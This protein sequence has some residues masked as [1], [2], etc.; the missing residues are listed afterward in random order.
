[1][2]FG[3]F[4]AANAVFFLGQNDD[5]AALG[6]FVGERSQLRGVGQFLFG[7]AAQRLEFR[8]LAVAQRDGAGLVEQQ[9]IDVA[10]RLDG[11][12]GHR[13]Y[14]EAHQPVHA[15]NADGRQ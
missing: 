15:G 12:A 7:H 1:M 9:R 6:R 14:V 10:G 2:Q 11:A 3:E 5:G 4:T 8:R 13:Q